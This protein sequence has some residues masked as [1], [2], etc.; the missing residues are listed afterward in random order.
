MTLAVLAVAALGTLAVVVPVK[1]V[2]ALST[3]AL[4]L[5]VLS[6]AAQL[7]VTLVQ[8]QQASQVSAETQA[9]LTEMRATNSSLLANQRDH[10]GV[11]LKA[12]LQQAIPAAV[13]DVSQSADGDTDEDASDLEARSAELETAIKVRMEQA[14]AEAEAQLAQSSAVRA[15][16]SIKPLLS[17]SSSTAQKE[18][19]ALLSTFPSD[20]EGQPVAE[21]LRKLPPRAVSALGRLMADAAKSPS[22]RVIYRKRPDS[23]AS[24]MDDLVQN[25]LA[26]ILS[27]K[28]NKDGS[29]N[30]ICRLTPAGITAAR[31][32]RARGERPD[33]ATDL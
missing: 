31:I 27:I 7:I 32:L 16:P 23:A 11:L 17:T 8:A 33:W 29:E 26:E 24:G 2:D 18:W 19:D 22:R 25:G 21:L 1:N 6:F 13:D 15:S 9:A 10:V 5:A 28:M 3:I 4:A 30:R 12:A 14:L 20:D